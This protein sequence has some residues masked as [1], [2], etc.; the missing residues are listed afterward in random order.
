MASR[1]YSILRTENV[2]TM[3]NIVV[4]WAH[5]Y[6]TLDTPSAVSERL[7]LNTHDIASAYEVKAAF[8]ARL[9]EKRRSDAVLCVEYF[10]GPRPAYFDGADPKGER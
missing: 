4:S 5:N 6:R 1:P 2:K 7:H 9:P 3:C 8:V 10:I